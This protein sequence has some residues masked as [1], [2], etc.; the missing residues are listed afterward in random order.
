[1]Y[2]PVETTQHEENC[3]GVL[4]A[5]H[6]AGATQKESNPQLSP[7][8]MNPIM[9]KSHHRHTSTYIYHKA[10]PIKTNYTR[11]GQPYH[12]GS[13]MFGEF[14]P[15]PS[16]KH[17]KKHTRVTLRSPRVTWLTWFCGSRRFARWKRVLRIPNR[18]DLVVRG[19]DSLSAVQ[20]HWAL[21]YFQAL[22]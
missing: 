6:D 3:Y 10:E 11:Y 12:V 15:H 7:K 17:V 1:M 21:L 4:R 20:R 14:D 9:T 5:Q 8:N 19:C 18:E 13:S 2:K 22:L 16:A